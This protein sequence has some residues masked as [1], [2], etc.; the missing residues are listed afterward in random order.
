MTTDK[1]DYAPGDTA[2]ISGT[3]FW[4]GET[5]DLIVLHADGTPETGAD[6]GPWTVT[7]SPLGDIET[8]WHVCEDDCAG[9][10]L[11]MTATGQSSGLTATVSFGDDATIFLDGDFIELP[12]DATGLL[13][14]FMAAGDISG[15]K[16]NAAGTGGAA[17]VDFWV[18]GSPVYNYAI[19]FGGG[20]FRINGGSWSVG[21][22]VVDTSAGTTNSAIISGQP[23][24]GVTF[25]REVSFADNQQIIT[26]K[27][28]FVNAS[29]T[30][31]TSLATL[32]NTDPDQGTPICSDFFTFNDVVSAA[33][34][35][36]LVLA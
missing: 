14:R 24:L 3:G 10:V 27:D 7:A 31:L 19:A 18:W 16:Y 12:I 2:Y 29:G 22:T 6:H 15:A 34:I 26:I 25:T 32:D 1:S 23:Y 11:Q 36:D 28:T 4:P 17:G 30:T 33:G 21:P 20:N 9:S 13:G 5:V 8:T 35:N